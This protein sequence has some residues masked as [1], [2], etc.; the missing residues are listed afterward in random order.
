MRI[1]SMQPGS[2]LADVFCRLR[3]AID[4]ISDRLDFAWDSIRGFHTSCPS[5]LGTTMRAS[6][7]MRLKYSAHHKEFGNICHQFG[8]SI[9]GEYGEHTKGSEHRVYDISNRCRLGLSERD[10]YCRLYNGAKCLVRLE[11]SLASQN[12]ATNSH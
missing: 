3:R 7:L 6:F 1:I 8:L 12:L 10:I 9:R 2:K 5:N 4:F 11:K